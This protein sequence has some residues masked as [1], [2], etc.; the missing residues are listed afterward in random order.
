MATRIL[1]SRLKALSEATGQAF[2]LSVEDLDEGT[3]V[4]L[5]LP[6]DEIWGA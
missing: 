2:T 1:G 4:V 6:N 5:A 3:R